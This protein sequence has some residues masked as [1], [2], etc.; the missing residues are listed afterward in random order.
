MNCLLQTHDQ[1]VA[2][3][4]VVAA[5]PLVGQAFLTKLFDRALVNAHHRRK[6][7]Q[8]AILLALER[9]APDDR[10][11]SAAVANGALP[12]GGMRLLWFALVDKREH[13]LALGLGAADGLIG[14]KPRS[15][16]PDPPRQL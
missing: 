5:M 2:I 12:E 15:L 13:G 6:E 1:P 4:G 10:T 11:K 14:G 16:A 8:G 7:L 9:V 3:L